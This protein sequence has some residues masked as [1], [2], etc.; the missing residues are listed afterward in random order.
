MAI[1]KKV[2]TLA[3]LEALQLWIDGDFPVRGGGRK[4]MD[5]QWFDSVIKVWGVA[6]LIRKIDGIGEDKDKNKKEV[7]RI[8][9]NRF[10]GS[11]DKHL[12]AKGID[13]L[14]DH[15]RKRNLTS[16]GK[17]DKNGDQKGTRCTSLVSKVAFFIAPDTFPPWDGY[18]RD[19]LKKR[20]GRTF[21]LH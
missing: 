12:T 4:N 9:N 10:I 5:F 16:L 18:A 17:P 3:V 15:L 19:G 1:E 14:D 20:T 2:M 6:R 8:L 7:L 11:P 13:S 21:F